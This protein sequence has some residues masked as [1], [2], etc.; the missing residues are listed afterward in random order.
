VLILKYWSCEFNFLGL[1][2]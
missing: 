1:L 2:F